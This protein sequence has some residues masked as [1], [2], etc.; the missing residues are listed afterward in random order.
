MSGCFGNFIKQASRV[1][2]EPRMSARLL[3]QFRSGD[4]ERQAQSERPSTVA[5]CGH[6]VA[7]NPADPTLHFRRS[8][9]EQAKRGT[10]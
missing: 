6:S 4:I 9:A 8:Q 10:T 1:S 7:R 5:D 2:F 3:L